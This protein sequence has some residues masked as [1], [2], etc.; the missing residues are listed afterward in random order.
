MLEEMAI[1][2]KR[3][4]RITENCDVLIHIYDDRIEIDFRSLGDS[5]NPLEDTELDEHCNLTY[6]RKIS[7]SIEYDY[8]MGMNSTHIVLLRKDEPV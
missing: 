2:S 6:L 8:I 7:S 5:C 4:H 3:H 1:Y